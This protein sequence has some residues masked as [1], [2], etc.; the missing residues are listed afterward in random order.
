MQLCSIVIFQE[1]EKEGLDCSVL[2]YLKIRKG[3]SF[4][5]Q[6]SHSVAELYL[7]EKKIDAYISISPFF[8]GH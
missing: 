3:R 2:Q 8:K 7:G 4:P 5:S 6:L 1:N